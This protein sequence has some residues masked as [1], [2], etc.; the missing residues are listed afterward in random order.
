VHDAT[1]ERSRAGDQGFES[2][3][4]QRRVR[5]EPDPLATGTP[6][7]TQLDRYRRISVAA[8]RGQLKPPRDR[9]EARRSDGERL[10]RAGEHLATG[11]KPAVVRIARRRPTA[12]ELPP[13]RCLGGPYAVLGA[14]ELSAFAGVLTDNFSFGSK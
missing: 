14:R 12:V 7:N 11:L 8:T 9:D 1:T 6:V 5:N 13:P 10:R 4:L 3:S 2:L